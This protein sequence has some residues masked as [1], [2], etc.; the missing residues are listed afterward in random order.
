MNQLPTAP[1]KNVLPEHSPEPLTPSYDE[2]DYRE[3]YEL[4]D[5]VKKYIQEKQK[6]DQVE[7]NKRQKNALLGHQKEVDYYSHEISYYIEKQ[8]KAHIVHPPWYDTLVEAVFHENWGLAGIYEWVKHHGSSSSC[9][10][11]QPYIYFLENGVQTLKPQRL[12]KNRYNTL[13]KALLLNDTSQTERSDYH[14]LYMVD[15]TR[16]EIYN[17]HKESSGEGVI[18]FRRYTVKD[19]SFE[20]LA[21]LQ[22]IGHEAVP[23]L[24]HMVGCGYNVNMIGPVRSGKTTFLTT[25]QLYENPTL[26]GVLVE[27]DPEI[28]MHL[29]MPKAPIM[30][31]VSDGDKLE[32]LVKPLMR[33]DADYLIMGEARDGRAL[34]LMLLLTKKGTR[35][36]K[37]TFHTGH[38]QDFCYDVAQE[39]ANVYGGN[40]W[41]YMI[42]AA[43]NFN[44]LFEFMSDPMDKSKKR[45]KGIHEIRFNP[46][47]MLIQTNAI[48][49]FDVESETWTYNSDLSEETRYQGLA[50]NRDAF[51]AFEEELKKLADQFSMKKH[52]NPIRTSPFSRL[53]PSS[54]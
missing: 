42:Q 36:V 22:T 4:C 54:K 33:S 23:L 38:A 32:T 12:S 29:L 5:N 9:K 39:I 51:L 7:W 13:K 21:D 15:G 48:C 1:K 50:E 49:L 18:I 3:F 40:I 8:H 16:I 35:R 43:T 28:P 25:Y 24:T 46:D 30:Q 11:I 27:T 26:E 31:L 20:R 41:A 19:Y 10:I 52:Q 45:M 6:E 37:A 2:E 47:T 17:N 53:V 14:E 34:R 44:F